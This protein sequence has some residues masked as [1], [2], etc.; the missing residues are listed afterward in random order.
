M[1]ST[2]NQRPRSVTPAKG[3]PTAARHDTGP[4]KRDTVTLQWTALGVA[5]MAV[6]GGLIYFGGDWGGGTV[7]HGGGGHGAPAVVVDAAFVDRPGQP[8]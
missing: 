7:N 6:L 2:K 1:A 8:G 4:V 5:I 3:R